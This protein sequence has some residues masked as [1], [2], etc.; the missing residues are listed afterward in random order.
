[1]KNTIEWYNAQEQSWEID[2]EKIARYNHILDEITG[3]AFYMLEA[4]DVH[5]YA[6]ELNNNNDPKHTQEI[7]ANDVRR[8]NMQAKGINQYEMINSFMD[9]ETDDVIMFF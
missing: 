1:M 5:F 8:L 7:T 2:K 9:D 4:R 3:A 6:S